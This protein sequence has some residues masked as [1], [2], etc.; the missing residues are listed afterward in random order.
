MN[1]KNLK[2]FRSIIGESDFNYISDDKK[3]KEISEIMLYKLPQPDGREAVYIERIQEFLRNLTS[4]YGKI[5]ENSYN[6]QRGFSDS[7]KVLTICLR[8]FSEPEL[9]RKSVSRGYYIKFNK[10]FLM[11]LKEL[12]GGL[13][14]EFDVYKIPE[15]KLNRDQLLRY[16]FDTANGLRKRFSFNNANNQYAFARKI[17]ELSDQEIRVT[18]RLLLQP[19]NNVRTF[20]KWRDIGFGGGPVRILMYKNRVYF[21]FR[22]NNAEHGAYEHQLRN[23]RPD[24][25]GFSTF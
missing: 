11:G 21:L 10:R 15:I 23:T 2:D 17:Q 12:A 16:F 6:L 5:Y 8:L 19:G 25:A 22:N 9:K 18:L 7:Q 3:I 14:K 24:N 1:F 20:N 13:K 4:F